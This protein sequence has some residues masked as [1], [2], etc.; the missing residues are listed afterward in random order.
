MRAKCSMC[1]YEWDGEIGEKCPICNSNILVDIEATR[2]AEVVSML[3]WYIFEIDKRRI[4]SGWI[5]Q[6]L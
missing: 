6:K 1:K 3:E 5:K 2:A 4:I